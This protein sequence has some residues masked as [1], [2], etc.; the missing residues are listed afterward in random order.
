MFERPVNLLSDSVKVQDL[1][2]LVFTVIMCMYFGCWHFV[3]VVRV[4]YPKH[5][6]HPLH[7]FWGG[8]VL[9]FGTSG[10]YDRY[11][12]MKMYDSDC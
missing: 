8:V 5:V 9:L 7:V 1:S 11:Y 2:L 6:D 3:S 4:I 12:V 10:V